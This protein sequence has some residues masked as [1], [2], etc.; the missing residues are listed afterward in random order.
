MYTKRCKKTSVNNFSNIGVD[1][2]SNILY[3]FV[4]KITLKFLFEKSMYYF[5]FIYRKYIVFVLEQLNLQYFLTIYNK[6]RS[7]KERY[8]F[9]LT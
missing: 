5:V 3:Y 8:V 7:M 2:K 6:T 4:H 9:T 1:D